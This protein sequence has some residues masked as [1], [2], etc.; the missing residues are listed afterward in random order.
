MSHKISSRSQKLDHILHS[1]PPMSLESTTPIRSVPVKQQSLHSKTDQ[2]SDRQRQSQLHDFDV[3]VQSGQLSETTSSPGNQNFQRLIQLN[4]ALY[5]ATRSRTERYYITQ[6]I[7]R[8]IR[9]E[10][11][12]FLQYVSAWPRQHASTS[13]SPSSPDENPPNREDSI[14][15]LK[16]MTDEQAET[17]T[18]N[19]LDETIRTRQQRQSQGTDLVYFNNPDPNITSPRQ[20]QVNPFQNTSQASCTASGHRKPF[21]E[22]QPQNPIQGMVQ[23]KPRLLLKESRFGDWG[24][25]HDDLE[26]RQDNEEGIRDVAFNNTNQENNPLTIGNNNGTTPFPPSPPVALLTMSGKAKLTV[27]PIRN[28]RK[29]LRMDAV[30]EED[31]SS[32]SPSTIPRLPPT[33]RCHWQCID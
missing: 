24:C 17:F 32:A 9:H 14:W 20:Q 8:S 28:S 13:S 7:V 27:S 5:E 16:E 21:R 25:G 22:L 3:L 29:R 31:S 18:G 30:G 15:I 33:K 12:R 4:M 26:G 2:R 23:E 10:G 6:S 19:A 11:G 1:T